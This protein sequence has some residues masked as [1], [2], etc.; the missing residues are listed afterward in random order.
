MSLLQIVAELRKC[1]CAI[2]CLSMRTPSD[3]EHV[4]AVVQYRSTFLL[5]YFGLL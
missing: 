1:M 2:V 5:L 3:P 4:M